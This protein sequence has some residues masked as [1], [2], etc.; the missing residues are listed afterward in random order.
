MPRPV[1]VLLLLAAPLAWAQQ[2]SQ[3]PEPK[4]EPGTG[5]VYSV[6]A[7]KATTGKD[8]AGLKECPASFSDGVEVLQEL[9]PGV[10]APKATKTQPAKFPKDA[11]EAMK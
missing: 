4:L 10:V 2:S 9:K 5:L 1:C 6:P 7:G 11:R 3:T 8:S